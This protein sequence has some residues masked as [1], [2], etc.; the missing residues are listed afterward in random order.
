M[1]GKDR[2]ILHRATNNWVGSTSVPPHLNSR[3]LSRGAF[4]DN[5]RLRY[6]L[7]PQ[8]I[9]TACYGCGKKL[10]IDR[11]IS[12]PRGGLVLARHDNAAK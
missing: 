11:A 10:L 2:Q 12:C 7:M 3:E 9:P 6:G 8:D 5:F 1:G 4:Q